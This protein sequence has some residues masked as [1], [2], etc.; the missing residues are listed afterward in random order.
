MPRGTDPTRKFAAAGFI[1]ALVGLADAAYLTSKHLAGTAVPCNLV[2]GCETVLNST[3]AEFYGLPTAL[4]GAIAYFAAFALAFLVF[5]GNKSLWKAF[6]LLSSVMFVFSVY[7][8]YL[9]A[10]V[11]KAF[12]QY[13]LVSAGTSTILFLIFLLSLCFAGNKQSSDTT[14]EN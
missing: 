2:S 4:Y 8:I 5:S 7:L 1:T 9:Q 3:W 13:C 10:W 14:P 12:C 6:G 11:I